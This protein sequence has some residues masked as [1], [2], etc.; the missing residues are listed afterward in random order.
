MK[1]LNLLLVI[2][3]TA[4]IGGSVIGATANFSKNT[5]ENTTIKTTQPKRANETTN[6]LEFDLPLYVKAKN[7]NEYNY[8]T[9]MK[10]YNRKQEYSNYNSALRGNLE[11]ITQLKGRTIQN[12][13]NSSTYIE[14]IIGNTYALD[15][16]TSTLLKY[17]LI[18]YQHLYGVNT[19]Q[20]IKTT[21]NVKELTIP[22]VK[23]N[24][25]ITIL[26]SYQNWSTYM[27]Q[28]NWNAYGNNI[29]IINEI[30]NPQNE[31]LYSQ[32]INT[33]TITF[34]NLATS[35]KLTIETEVS[36][37]D[38]KTNY[39]FILIQ[40]YFETTGN[41]YQNLQTS[42]P[43]LFA[44]IEDTNLPHISGY[45]IPPISDYEVIDIP[46]IMFNILT[47]PFAFISTAFNLTLF[48]GTP[49][50]LNLSNLFLTIIAIMIFV[51][52]I[53]IMFKK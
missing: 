17:E 24:F 52:I 9:D 37:L 27:G 12:I 30:T 19:K 3:L 36:L 16:C 45:M 38:N 43:F 31:Q 14:P 15:N 21:I 11:M 47:M 2:G 6:I 34:T 41:T 25:K 22:Q 28:T 8:S 23:L 20:T 5:N 18:P 32:T 53:R 35:H 33:K 39:H 7:N 50:Q 46:S 4:I 40:P 44:Y 13:N 49:Y 10:I 51:F 48:P 26:T 29:N 42:N 1:K